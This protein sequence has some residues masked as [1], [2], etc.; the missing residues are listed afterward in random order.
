MSGARVFVMLVALLATLL[1]FTSV[2]RA[3]QVELR[4]TVEPPTIEV[5]EAASYS[6]VVMVHGRG[7]PTEVKAGPTNG[8][9]MLGSTGTAPIHMRSI[10]NGVATEVNG[11]TTTWR[12]RGD[13]EGTFTLGPAQVVIDGAKKN[14]PAAK[15]T[16]VG[17]GKAPKRTD[18]FAGTPF[19][20]GGTPFDPFKGLFDFD[21][22][23]RPQEPIG[24]T[25]DPKLSMDAPRQPVAFLH[26]VIDKYRAV[27][28]EQVTLT[29][30]LYED[31][32]AHQGRPGDVHEPT[33]NDFVKRSL[34]EDE[35]RAVGLGTAS[36]GGK[37]WNVKLVRKNALFPLKTGRLVIEPMSMSLPQARVGLRESERLAVDVS[38]P[39]VDGRPAGYAMGDVGDMALSATVTPR[40]V[41]REGA[42]GVTVEL[43]GTGNLPSQLTLPVV[44]GA[45]WL[46]PQLREKLGAQSSDRFGGSRTFSYV[47]RLH[48]EGSIDL[49]EIR[50]PYYD[51][52][53]KIYGIGRASL[54]I[55][56]VGPGSGRDAGVDEPEVV[57][58]GMPKT[59]RA[60]E[61]AHPQKYLSETPIFWAAIF[62]SPLACA[63]AASAH[64]LV[65]RARERR[66]NAAPSPA[67]IAKERRAE[68]D[69]ACRA[70]DGGAAMGAVARAVQAAVLARTGVNLR[71]AA[72]E[73]GEADLV[74]AGVGGEQARAVVDVVRTCEDARFSPD[75]VSIDEARAA[76]AKGRD[77]VDAL[78][79]G[80]ATE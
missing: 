23:D 70:D 4:A 58:A 80:K 11:L 62:G 6:V 51:A 22:S 10:V 71:G 59:R 45:E 64:G 66:A 17:R 39:P 32:Y 73:E 49:G 20:G 46:E 54:G 48:K 53:K 38:E 68:A 43:R 44:P 5:G 40:A 21:D 9:T 63:I 42:I 72:L 67:R 2:A 7:Q 27:V 69:A 65:R 35:T 19:A 13:R 50:L 8:V 56:N 55:V 52:E 12:V 37:P 57:L 3:D 14:I 18:P 30:Y 61:G 41:A 47:V 74:A 60:L 28:G 16:V 75:G 77:A 24:P 26:S 31:P 29:V 79:A 36:V 76:W 25:A 1:A 33:A 34:I 78:P 15:L